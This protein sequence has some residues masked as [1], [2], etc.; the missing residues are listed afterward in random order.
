MTNQNFPWLIKISRDLIKISRDLIKISHDLIKI[1]RDPVQ[2][3][4][5]KCHHRKSLNNYEENSY[6]FVVENC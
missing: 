3:K 5:L 1:S 6:N 2:K 4:S